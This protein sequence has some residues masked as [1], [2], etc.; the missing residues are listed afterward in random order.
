MQF[1]MYFIHF[2]S[3]EI[4]FLFILRIKMNIVCFQKEPIIHD[5]PR[6][7]SMDLNSIRISTDR[8]RLEKMICPDFRNERDYVESIFKLWREHPISFVFGNLGR[9]PHLLNYYLDL[10]FHYNE[11]IQVQCH[12]ENYPSN[13]KSNHSMIDFLIIVEPYFGYSIV[14]PSNVKHLIV[15]SSHVCL[16]FYIHPQSFF[17]HLSSFKNQ[18]IPVSHLENAVNFIPPIFH[19][20]YFDLTDK[21]ICVDVT[22]SK[23]AHEAYMRILTGREI[24]KDAS[25]CIKIKKDFKNILQQQLAKTKHEIQKFRDDKWISRIYWDLFSQDNE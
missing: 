20:E 6:D 24:C 16:N 1:I 10:C 21:F 12:F 4:S 11:V 3:Y 7:Q 13:Y 18:S 19:I 2:S 25:V 23:T 15:L 5:I 22:K 9:Q 8:S 17:L 14:K